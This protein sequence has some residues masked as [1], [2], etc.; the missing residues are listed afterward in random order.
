MLK[1]V[2][3]QMIEVVEPANR[4]FERAFLIVR[5]DCETADIRDTAR[6]YVATADTCAAM[7]LV[8]KQN[9]WRSRFISAACGS[10]GFLAGLAIGFLIRY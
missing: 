9:R 10:T 7:R 4:Y 2:N 6:R 5:G 3:R 1:G 8:K